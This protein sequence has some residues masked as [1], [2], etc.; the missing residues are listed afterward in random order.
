MQGRLFV[1]MVIGNASMICQLSS[2]IDKPLIFDVYLLGLAH[3]V[4]HIDDFHVWV[5]F[6]SDSFSV[7]RFDEN[8]VL[9]R[10][11]VR[12]GLLTSRGIVLL[13]QLPVEW[14]WFTAEH[15]SVHVVG[16]TI[17][18]VVVTTATLEL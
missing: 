15:H 11:L 10:G 12:D 17:A 13:R 16:V 7:Q 3:N 18:R 4:F 8:L 6:Q 2:S 1:N 14:R 9:L 5:H